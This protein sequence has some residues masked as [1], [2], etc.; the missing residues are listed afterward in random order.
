MFFLICGEEKRVFL[1]RT[2]DARAEGSLAVPNS[3]VALA[4]STSFTFW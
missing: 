3:D 1:R 2:L 4:R